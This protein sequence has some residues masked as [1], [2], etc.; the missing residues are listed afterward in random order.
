MC[1]L[2]W[3]FKFYMNHNGETYSVCKLF[4]TINRFRH[5]IRMN[6]KRREER[7]D[8]GQSQAITG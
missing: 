5:S 7:M 3:K 4:H 8:A 1:I 6:V 2:V